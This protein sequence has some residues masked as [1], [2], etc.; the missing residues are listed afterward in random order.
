M[1]M[2]LLIFSLLIISSVLVEST[3]TEYWSPEDAITKT[4]PTT[5]STETTT[6]EA[7][8]PLNYIT[9]SCNRCYVED[10]DGACRFSILSCIF[11]I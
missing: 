1:K 2:M 9:N 4:E 8:N 3:P 7:V 6:L 11:R 5:T 10:S